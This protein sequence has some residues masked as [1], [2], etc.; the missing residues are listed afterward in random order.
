MRRF[1]LEHIIRAASAITK[2]DH[3]VVVGSQAILAQFPKPIRLSAQPAIPRGDSFG[4]EADGVRFLE[5]R[6]NAPDEWHML[7]TPAIFETIN[8]PQVPEEV[9]SVVGPYPMQHSDRRR[10][11]NCSIPIVQSE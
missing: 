3:I 11:S 9:T 2:Q 1:E 7:A 4:Q 8:K 6:Q 5:K 10:F